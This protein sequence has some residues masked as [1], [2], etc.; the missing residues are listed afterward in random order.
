MILP[1]I[2]VNRKKFCDTRQKTMRIDGP[3]GPIY[4]IDCKEAS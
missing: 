2:G 1:E 4:A 3:P